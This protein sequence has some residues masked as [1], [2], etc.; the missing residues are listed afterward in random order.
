MF[1]DLPGVLC[2]MMLAVAQSTVQ[3]EVLE[4]KACELAGAH[5]TAC[6]LLSAVQF[7]RTLIIA[8]DDSQVSYLEG[9]TAPSY[10]TNQVPAVQY[11]LSI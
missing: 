2:A 6:S 5:I 4:L 7:E 9:C 1:P 11:S 10:D 8:E 3:L